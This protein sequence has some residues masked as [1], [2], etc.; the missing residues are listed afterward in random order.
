MFEKASVAA[1]HHT[2]K[3]ATSD[4]ER[5]GGVPRGL[6]LAAEHHAAV[7][8]PVA[9]PGAAIFLSVRAL[10]RRHASAAV[11]G[12]AVQR[13]VAAVRAAAASVLGAVA[14]LQTRARLVLETLGD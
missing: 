3:F 7:G 10:V 13:A 12:A 14:V 1:D 11:V 4:E 9:M 5:R 2:C 6:M 8:C